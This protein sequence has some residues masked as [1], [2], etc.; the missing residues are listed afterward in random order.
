MPHRLNKRCKTCLPAQGT[1]CWSHVFCQSV[2]HLIH[3]PYDS[4]EIRVISSKPIDVSSV[5]FWRISSGCMPIVVAM[6]KV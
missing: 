5:V 4:E 6:T 2:P 1:N 3:G